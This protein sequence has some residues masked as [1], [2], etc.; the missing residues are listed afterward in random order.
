MTAEL[1]Q[2]GAWGGIHICGNAPTNAEGGVGSSEIGGATYGGNITD[3]NS[4][5]L[6][7]VRVEYGGYTIT[8]DTEANG[9]TF[10]G[11]G[12]GTTVDHCVA[13]KGSDDGFEWFGGT[14]NASNLVSINNSDDSL[15]GPRDGTAPSPTSWLTKH[16]QTNWAMTATV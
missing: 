4:G 7:Y 1:K 9:F 5:I 14:V 15:T 16:P 11:V 12:S 10:Y 3:D 2:A 8:E 6:Q 13:Y